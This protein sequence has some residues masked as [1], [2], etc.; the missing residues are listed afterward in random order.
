MADIM[1][2]NAVGSP[3]LTRELLTGDILENMR[4]RITPAYAGTTQIPLQCL[5]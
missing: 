4:T 5:F 1:R 3:P 2:Q